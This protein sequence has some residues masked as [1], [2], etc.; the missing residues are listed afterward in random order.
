MALPELRS[1]DKKFPNQER[2]KLLARIID[3]KS[4]IVP[5][6]PEDKVKTPKTTDQTDKPDK[7]DKP[8]KIGGKEK[9]DAMELNSKR[10]AEDQI[11]MIRVY[12]I[13][14][15]TKPAVLISRDAI[16]DLFK[17]HMDKDAVPK[18]KDRQDRFR[19]LNGYDQMK[20][21]F[22]AKARELYPKIKVKSDPESIKVFRE[23]VHANYV[24]NYCGTNECHGGPNGGDFF[25]F[26]RDP[27]NVDPTVYTNFYTLHEYK[28]GPGYMLDFENPEKS[29]LLQFGLPP[30]NAITP[31]PVV[32][33]WRHSFNNSSDPR[34]QTILKWISSFPKAKNDYGINWQPPK[35]GDH[36]DT[37][38]AEPT[39]APAKSPEPPLPLPPKP[40]TPPALPSGQ[41][42]TSGPE[43]GK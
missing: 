26:N 10:L 23:K 41:V 25:V 4:K 30:A 38:T 28:E 43:K 7:T 20:V 37:P 32:K 11:N 9:I 31:H 6:V 22:A 27:S 36:K 35:F 16:D 29:Y 19:G 42:H 13:D 24:L 12:E 18:G 21:F 33:G 1:F 34:Y 5:A 40:L 14:P 8:E 2:S 17:N 3:E 15:E 39:T